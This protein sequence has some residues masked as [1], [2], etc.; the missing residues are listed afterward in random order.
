MEYSDIP[1]VERQHEQELLQYFTETS[2]SI[3]AMLHPTTGLPADMLA[4]HDD[5]SFTLTTRTS[6]TNI[7]LAIP[8]IVA[9][10]KMGLKSFEIA[11]H[12]V[13]RIVNS[14][15]NM[16]DTG[17]YH[18]GLY[19]NWVN[20]DGTIFDQYKP[21]ASSVDHAWLITG[22]EVGEHAL[23][24][25][26]SELKGLREHIAFEKF[27]DPAEGLILGELSFPHHVPE[28]W[29]YRVFRTEARQTAYVA[30]LYGLSSDIALHMDSDSHSWNGSMFEVCMPLMF[31]QE[32]LDD[33]R[34]YVETQ[35][36]E[37]DAYELW[38]KSPCL[39]P[40]GYREFGVTKLAKSTGIREESVISPYSS[41]Q[42][43]PFGNI[44]GIVHNISNL[45]K[46]YPDLYIEGYGF[47]DSV[48]TSTGEVVR[49]QLF[50]DQAMSLLPLYN[51]LSGNGLH[52]FA[53]HINE[54][55]QAVHAQR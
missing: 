7:G 33:F 30:P 23:P 27:Y 24:T 9:Q 39:G 28:S 5:G 53:P 1:C 37:C 48:D 3:D 54:V 6:L 43:L 25:L 22:L 12:E 16:N 13:E 55:V 45:R 42:A 47:G 46:R 26:A 40:H 52:S 19:N 20:L 44:P 2:A 34:P 21:H 11:E 31:D 49:T 51:Q 35:I 14:L 32:P 50:V 29:K 38:G 4:H 15:Q 8:C 18:D 41:F 36:S 10:W 17:A